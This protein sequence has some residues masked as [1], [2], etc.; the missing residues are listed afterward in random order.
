[1]CPLIKD[2]FAKHMKYVRNIFYKTLTG[3]WDHQDNN[4]TFTALGAGAGIGTGTGA[5]AS[6]STGAGAGAGAGVGAGTIGGSISYGANDATTNIGNGGTTNN[7]QHYM[8][9]HID[10]LACMAK[11]SGAL[12]LCVASDRYRGRALLYHF[13]Q[14]SVCHTKMHAPSLFPAARSQ[15]QT[16]AQAQA[17]AQA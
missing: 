2:D 4:T 14:L 11:F 5:D 3:A 9:G 16:Q 10:G 12:A 15:V 17:Q 1:M 8:D 13:V 7:T 6:V